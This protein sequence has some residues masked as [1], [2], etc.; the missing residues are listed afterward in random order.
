[1]THKETS[2][3]LFGLN[4]LLKV[5]LIEGLLIGS[6]ALLAGRWTWWPGWIFLGVF[7]LYSLALFGW[8]AGVDPD[9][10]RER[11][12]DADPRNEPYEKVIIPLMVMLELGLLVVSVLDG[13]RF[14]WST[15]P[16]M[17]RFVGW[18]LLGVTGTILP[19]V[20]RTN[21]FA[22]GI[23]RIQ[24]DRD[25]QVVVNGPYRIVRHPM[26]AGVISGMLGLPLALGSWWALIPAGLLMGLFV[27]RTVLEDRM[28]LQQL[29]EYEEYAQ[30]TR[31]RLLPG[32][33]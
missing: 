19:W 23:G 5:I 10:V 8:L 29:P 3:D 33:W 14:G 31:Y 12:R 22:S 21:T 2:V 30:Q 26:Y 11:Q 16:L 24:E 28:L 13:G 25:H 20:F 7:T 9:L 17:A 18:F 6:M 27:V 1:M 32:I 4:S 15:V